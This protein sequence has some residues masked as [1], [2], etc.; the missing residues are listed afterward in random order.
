M[1]LK[2]DLIQ[3]LQQKLIKLHNLELHNL[4]SYILRYYSDYNKQYQMEKRKCS[5]M[6]EV[7]KTCKS[8][9]KITW[10]VILKRRFFWHKH[11]NADT[12]QVF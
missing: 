5:R 11:V 12:Q 10:F 4:Y 6:T 9:Y 3:T 8:L 7:R 1:P 2:V